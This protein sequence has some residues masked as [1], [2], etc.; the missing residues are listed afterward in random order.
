M[1][2]TKRVRD[3]LIPIEEYESVSIESRLSDVL[4]TLKRNYEARK[5]LDNGEIHT[6]V[7]IKDSSERIVGKV[8]MYDLIRGL[9][10]ESVKGPEMS[11]AYYSVL[12]SRILE[13]TKEVSEVQARFKWLHSSFVDLIKQ[14]AQKSVKDVMSQ[15]HPLLKEDDTINHAIYI[16]F[17]ED[18]RQPLVVRDGEVIGVVTLKAIFDEMIELLGPECGVNWDD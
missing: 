8:S 12:S 10:P 6:T 9:V 1:E 14:E 16:M 5:H 3:I 11:R 4:A 15:V 7:F 18:V 17:K 2:D 13:V